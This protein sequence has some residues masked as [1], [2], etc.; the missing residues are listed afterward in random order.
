MVSTVP[1]GAADVLAEVVPDAPA[2]LFDVVYAP[3]PTPLAVRWQASRGEVI[4]GL[5]LL[6]HQAVLQLV[7]MTG[8]APPRR[9]RE[10]HANGR[11]S[12]PSGP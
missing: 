6:V 12:R 11:P 1:S 10:C 7:L 3:W 9:P 8:T 4:G 2:T 5:D